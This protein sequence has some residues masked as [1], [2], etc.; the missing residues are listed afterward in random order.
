MQGA[1]QVFGAFLLLCGVFA[2]AALREPALKGISYAVR[3]VLRL[4]GS[5]T[6]GRRRIRGEHAPEI[7]GLDVSDRPDLGIH[8]KYVLS[9]YGVDDSYFAPAEESTN[10]AEQ[11]A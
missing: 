3:W 6:S 11:P 9:K 2:A 5:S 4:E 7:V 8:E 1:G 10:A